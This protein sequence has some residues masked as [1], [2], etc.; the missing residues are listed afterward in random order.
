MLAVLFLNQATDLIGTLERRFYDFSS[1][2]TTRLPSDRIAIIAIDDQSIANIGRWPWPRDIHAKLIDMLSA[3]KAKTIVETVFF[4]EPQVDRGL[5]Y[6]RQMKS[7]LASNPDA[8]NGALSKVIAEAEIALD[9]DAKLGVSIAK[10][11]NVL[12]PSVYV[13]GEQQGR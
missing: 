1:T 11:G 12:V 5:S 8:G 4:I 6:I 13:L 9:T 7:L 3:A 10:A 2:S